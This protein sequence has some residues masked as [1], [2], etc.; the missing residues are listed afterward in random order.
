VDEL[1]EYVSK[2]NLSLVI[3]GDGQQH[4]RGFDINGLADL[5]SR[6]DAES[7]SIKHLVF[8]EDDVVRAEVIKEI[9]RMY[10]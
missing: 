6:I 5:V 7:E 10:K 9:L 3:A 4:D 2:K 1:I 8:T